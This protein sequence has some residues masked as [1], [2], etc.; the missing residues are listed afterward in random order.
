M[1][2]P[3]PQDGKRISPSSVSSDKERDDHRQE[4]RLAHGEH[5]VASGRIA[6]RLLLVV[7]EQVAQNRH[8][9]PTDQEGENV[10]RSEDQNY[11]SH[12]SEVQQAVAASR[13]LISGEVVR[14]K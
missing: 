14:S 4:S 6:F 8:A 1:S 5:D 3:H 12:Q 7:D 11:G 13:V 9:L 2:S 10:A